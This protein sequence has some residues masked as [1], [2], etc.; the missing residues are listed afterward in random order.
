MDDKW[1]PCIQ[2]K[3]FYRDILNSYLMFHRVLFIFLGVEQSSMDDVL[4]L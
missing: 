1:Q 2:Q 3:L 4:L